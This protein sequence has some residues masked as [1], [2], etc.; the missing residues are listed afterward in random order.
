LPLATSL[1]IRLEGVGKKFYQRW[2][3][4]GIDHDFAATPHLALVGNNGSGKSTLLRIIAGQLAASEGRVRCS[5]ATRPL[6]LVRLYRHLSWAGPYIEPYPELTLVE[7]L[8]LHFRFRRCLLP[9]HRALVDLLDLKAHRD[10]PLQRY[11]SGMLQR[12]KVGTALFTQSEILLLDEP[13]SNM[14]TGNAERILALIRE[15]TQDRLLVLASNLSREYE[16]MP[17]IIK[18]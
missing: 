16:D 4:R 12:V 9:Q 13:T 15:H 1:Q 17:R 5:Y 3:F 8:D 6:P 2:L 7:H 11:S 18:L 10:K 14:D